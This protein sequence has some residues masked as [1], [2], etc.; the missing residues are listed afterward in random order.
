MNSS[1]FWPSPLDAHNT[2]LGSLVRPDGWENPEPAGVY[3][4]VVVGAGTAGLISA[5]IA[6]SL[7]AKVALVEKRLMGG[8][9]LNSGCIP[10]KT[11][12]RSARA[13]DQW[14]KA[15]S[16]GLPGLAPPPAD[17]AAVMERVRGIR[18]RVAHADAAERYREMGVDVFFGEGRFTGPRSLEVGGQ[19]LRFAKAVIATGARAVTP[20]IPGIDA[21][22]YLTNDSLF[23][24]TTQP[25]HLIIIGGG[26]I[27]CEMAQAFRRL[28]SQVTIVQSSRFLPHEDPEAS[29]MLAG[30]FQHE[31]IE[32]L[33]DAKVLE[34]S[35]GGGDTKQL[36]V[37]H[38][39]SER[40]I[41]GDALLVGAGRAAEVRG[42]GLELAGVEYDA[43]K[44][45]L[46][47]DFLRTSNVRIYAAGDCCMAWK[48][49]H[50]AEAAAQIVVQNAL[51]MGRK[52]LSRLLMPWC[53]YTDPEIAHVG[54]YEKEAAAKGLAVDFFKFSMTE[55][56]RAVTD[57]ETQGFVKIMVKKGTDRILGA[58]IVAAHAGEMIS[59]ITAIMVAGVGL[60]ALGRVIHPYPTQAEA[61]KRAAW[62]YKKSRLTP[63]VRSLLNRWLR[64]SRRSAGDR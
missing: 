17:F 42:M 13:L 36:L 57:G 64:W 29:A 22:E 59:E 25:E 35:R 45:I 44:G 39:G 15:A 5:A 23:E 11:L 12:I 16:F 43:H 33:L 54:M 24:L 3:N 8:D 60:N 20:S 62:L 6:A 50:A 26:P 47:D 55:N 31:G 34:A 27:G 37:A 53:T 4:L 32:V 61:I 14:R 58:T 51:F 40:R 56:D 52:R 2:Q 49:T 48:F 63:W 10:S 18:A 19:T 1:P 7:G 41:T 38:N 46:V 9:C 30:V 28:G 21:V